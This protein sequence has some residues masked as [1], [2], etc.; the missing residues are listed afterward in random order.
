M[1]NANDCLNEITGPGQINELKLKHYRDNGAISNNLNDAEYEYL[2]AQGV[3]KKHISDMWHEF[4]KTKGFSGALND[5]YPEYL[6]SINSVPP[7]EVTH[8][9]EEVTHQSESVVY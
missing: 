1:S 4:L 7:E 8:Q 5:M 6:C 9:S 3:S 2:L